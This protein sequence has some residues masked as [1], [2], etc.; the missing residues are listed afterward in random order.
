ME[1]ITGEHPFWVAL[2]TLAVLLASGFCIYH[3][4]PYLGAEAYLKDAGFYFVTFFAWGVLCYDCAPRL[5]PSFPSGKAF[6]GVV[7]VFIAAA[8]LVNLFYFAVWGE[9]PPP[10]LQ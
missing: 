6:W 9:L 5:C 10:R 7:T 1:K 4:M 8:L 2:R 3:L